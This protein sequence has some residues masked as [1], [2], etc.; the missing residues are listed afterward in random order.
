MPNFELKVPPPAVLL[1][2]GL[3]MWLTARAAPDFGF[4][5]PARNLWAILL[6]AGGLIVGFSGVLTFRK[7]RTTVNPTTPQASSSLVTWGVYRLTRNPMYFG[8]LIVLT[9]WAIFLANALVF[10]FLPAYILYIGRFQITPEERALSALFGQE[11]AAY[12]AR[13]RRWI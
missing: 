12:R 4:V 5:V 9:G 1:V 11:Y 8:L 3:L 7:A 6:I 13:V 10:L 2:L